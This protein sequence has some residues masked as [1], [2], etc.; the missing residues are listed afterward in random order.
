MDVY[1]YYNH[2]V[3]I[4]HGILGQ[5]WGKK[6]GPPYPLGYD[7]HSAAEKRQNSI[8]VLSGQANALKAK[9][10]KK[11]DDSWNEVGKDYKK[12]GFTDEQIAALKKR[13]E[14][15][16]KV[17]AVALG[18]GVAYCL[19]SNA[20]MNKDFI[21]EAG[22]QI[23]R[24]SSS[25]D[26]TVHDMFY[27]ATNKLDN[28]KYAGHMA[29][30]RKVKAATIRN[31]AKMMGADPDDIFDQLG[32]AGKAFSKRPYNNIYE[33]KNKTKIAGVNTCKDVYKEL[34]KQAMA[35][36]NPKTISERMMFNQEY[37]KS[38]SKFNRFTMMNSRD[39]DSVKKFVSEIKKRGYGGIVDYNDAKASG[40]T[41]TRPVIFFGQENNVNLKS[42]KKITN[43]TM[44]KNLAESY[45][46]MAVQQYLNSPGK[47]ALAV[48]AGGFYSYNKLG[49]K[50][51]EENKAKKL[52]KSSKGG[53]TR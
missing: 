44:Y 23:Y 45:P 14:T 46:V 8:T 39:E 4:H 40:Y 29:Y 32:D 35:D 37:P 53:T 27:A 10:K 17:G 20:A 11:Y 6:N 36:Y 21:L 30:S 1:V 18:V 26:G 34:R 15:I 49:S 24:V 16:A 38:Y 31:T 25:D 52:K 33:L 28:K 51:E 2:D 5:K 19:V 42:S 22:K 41:S 7:D 43:A 3:L 9:A 12:E 50:Y 47:M 13:A 48:G